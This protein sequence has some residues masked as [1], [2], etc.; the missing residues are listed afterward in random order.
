MWKGYLPHDLWFDFVVLIKKI[1]GVKKID[2]YTI[3][4]LSDWKFCINSYIIIVWSIY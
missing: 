4:L 3:R 2:Y 1:V